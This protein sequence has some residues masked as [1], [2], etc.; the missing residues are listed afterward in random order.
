[1]RGKWYIW[2][3]QHLTS[4]GNGLMRKC[5]ELRN[6]SYRRTVTLHIKKKGKATS[7]LKNSYL[8]NKY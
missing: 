4:V 7:I 5:S 6:V 8:W 2:A 3:T 1:L